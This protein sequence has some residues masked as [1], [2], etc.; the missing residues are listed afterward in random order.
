MAVIQI[1]SKDGRDLCWTVIPY[2][3]SIIRSMK[4][5]GYK[6]RT[7]DDPS[8]VVPKSVDTEDEG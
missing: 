1:V 5:A 2:P 3:P 4:Q 8:V 7:I 6:V